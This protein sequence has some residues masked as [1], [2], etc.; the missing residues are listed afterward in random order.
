MLHA[1]VAYFCR[2][3]IFTKI[4]QGPDKLC[5]L[6]EILTLEIDNQAVCIDICKQLVPLQLKLFLKKI[7]SRSVAAQID[8]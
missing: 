4:F 8:W 2:G 5:E 6:I 7:L 1:N 3:A